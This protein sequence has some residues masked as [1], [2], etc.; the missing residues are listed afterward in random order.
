MHGNE[1]LTALMFPS[2]QRR[3]HGMLRLQ[4]IQRCVPLASDCWLLHRC[5]ACH[6]P[7]GGEV[8]GF[9]GLEENGK[10][11]KQLGM[12]LEYQ[13]ALDHGYLVRSGMA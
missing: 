9:R 11:A 8:L 1:E 5:A 7:I 13:L 12:H 10:I 3:V 4:G 2:D 6:L